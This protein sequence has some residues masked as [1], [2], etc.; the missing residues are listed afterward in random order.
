M[1]VLTELDFARDANASGQV[2]PEFSF[3]AVLADNGDVYGTR[4][5]PGNNITPLHARCG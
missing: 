5:A 3:G 1:R 4:D 2:L